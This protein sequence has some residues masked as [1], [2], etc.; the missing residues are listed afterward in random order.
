VRKPYPALSPEYF[1]PTL[2]LK[3]PIKHKRQKYMM[4]KPVLC[5]ALTGLSNFDFYK[6][7][8]IDRINLSSNILISRLVNFNTYLH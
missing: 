4:A 7:D 6:G 2:C 1:P 3:D 8:E 5:F